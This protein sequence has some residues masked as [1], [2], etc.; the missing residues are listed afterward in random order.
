MS[1][2]TF[3]QF[4]E[5]WKPVT[6]PERAASH[7]HF[8]DLCHVLGQPTPAAHD[9]T[10][11]EYTFEK[12]VPV[13]GPASKGSKGESGYVDAWWRGKF[14][15]EY[16]RKGKY[17]NLDEAYRQLCQYREALDNPPLLIVCDIN[18]IEIHTNFTG[19]AKTVHRI[20]LEDLDQPESIDKLRRV[21]TDPLSFKPTQTAANVTER[22]A[23]DIGQIAH[24]L[25]DRGHDPHD[26]AHFLMKCM[27]CLFAEDVDLLP[28]D[29]FAKLLARAKEAP[30]NFVTWLNELFEVMAKGGY[31]WGEPI[32]RFNGG[33]F[34]DSPAIELTATEIGTLILAAKQDWSSV[35]PAIFGTLFERSLDPSKRAQIGAH[36][37]SRDDIM[38]IVEPVILKPLRRE[39]EAVKE[40]VE[41]ELDRRRKAKTKATKTKA[42]K[43]IDAALQ[44]FLARLSSV[45]IL[46]PACGSG[47]FLYVAI[48]Q[49]L[50]LEKE[51]LTFAARKELGFGGLLPRVRPTQL[52]GIEINAYAAELAQVVI[53]IGYLQWMRDNGFNPPRDP[54]LDP[55]VTI[56][57]RDAILKWTDET[58]NPIPKYREGAACAGKADWPEADF[59]I[60]NPPFLGS[61]L[62]RKWGLPDPYIDAMYASFDI[63]NTSD[64]CC[65]W[66]E[67]AR[68]A[69]MRN[70]DTRAGLLATQG[71]RGGDNR[72]VLKRIKE[73]GDIFMAWSDRL[74]VLDGAAVRVSMIGFDSGQDL[75]RILD[76]ENVAE[77]NSDLTEGVNLG[78]AR[79]IGSNIGMSFMADTKGG[80]FDIEWTTAR[81]LISSPNPNGRSNCEV[82]VPWVNGMDVT[83]R[84]RGMWIVDFGS[85]SPIETA[86]QYEAP[87]EYVS[88]YVRPIRTRVRQSREAENWWLHVRP[89]G[90]MRDAIAGLRRFIATPLVAKHRLF[91]W[92]R[93]P[94]LVDHACVVFSRSDQYFLGVLH[95]CV[96]ELWAL[97]MGTQL[98]SRPRYTPTTCFETFPLPWPPGQEP[99]KGDKFRALHDAIA[100][101]ARELNEQRERWLNPPE[102]IEPIAEAVDKFE[103]FRGVPEDARPLLRES[104]IMA[105]AAKDAR[106]KKRTLTNLYNE[107]PTWL[108][109]AHR[110]L[111]EAVLAAY[112]AVD[113]EGGWEIEW[114]DAYEPFGAGHITIEKKDK[115]ETRAA[116]EAAIEARK[117]TDEKILAALL[118]L[119]QERAGEQA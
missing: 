102:W 112:R 73:T 64:L 27:F 55:L 29:R 30:E 79:P 4:I 96:H 46:D 113:P 50:D 58:G 16:K 87:F 107:R 2:L 60:G 45:R 76:A 105:R 70:S 84:Q 62:F 67:L 83:R 101:A 9:A 110:K 116:K 28:K 63:P 56:Q 68:L 115:P 91:T 61:K 106:L 71:I 53:W 69:I 104:A 77:V 89:R 108:R 94:T 117:E 54:I 88:E 49:L 82:V 20:D 19:T 43:A 93:H 95:S 14:G 32:Q 11:A 75:H 40:T 41:N 33:L 17:K 65:Y 6:L 80:A 18:H 119:N 35:E 47:N 111:D 15:W 37:T 26:V 12:A 99:D 57:E 66:F 21:F 31:F 13:L 103:D 52:L 92:M 85:E 97:R 44:G 38:L 1:S 22:V 90:D 34:D 5:K 42:D 24:A 10:G 3:A 23:K 86:S 78:L 36:Y 59:I 51:V 72:A 100:D 25:R 98:E 39:W 8:L 118:R 81:A 114:A 48:Q 109:L 7:E 74:W